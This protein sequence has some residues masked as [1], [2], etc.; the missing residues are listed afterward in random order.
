[1]D[2][3]APITHSGFIVLLGRPNVGKST[4]LNHILGQKIAIASPKPQ[5]TRNRVVGVLNRGCVQMIFFDTPGVH[6]GTKLI[7]RYM[8]REALS[9]L[10]DVDAV[11]LLVDAT[12]PP[13]PDDEGLARHL[14]AVRVP[15]LLAVN[16]IDLGSTPTAA[17]SH[18][19]PFHFT[20]RI[21]AVTGRGVQELLDALARILPEGPEYYPPETLT[22]RSERFIA[23]EFVREK[24]FELAGQ[25]VPYSVAVTVEQWREN[26]G[27]GLVT[28]YATIRVER[29]SQKGIIIGKGGQLIKEIGRRAR[30]DLEAL[31]GTR[32]Y[33]DLHVSVDRNWT[34]DPQALRRYGYEVGS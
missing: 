34:R 7:N 29:P 5:T 11:V 24:V 8:S 13:R 26:P 21:S 18:L 2:P 19:H 6:Q 9:C 10:P 28:I 17:F 14:E 20:H 23:Q 15:V 30:L 27:T 1:M 25:E 22:D 3:N 31:L 33:L 12:Q 16:K 32:V 4:L